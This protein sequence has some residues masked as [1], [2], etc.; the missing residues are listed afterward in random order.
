MFSTNAQDFSKLIEVAFIAGISEE[1][2]KSYNDNLTIKPTCLL[3]FP[4][5][6]ELVSSDVLEV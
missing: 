4:N 6:S 2:L 5:Q 3:S 1:N